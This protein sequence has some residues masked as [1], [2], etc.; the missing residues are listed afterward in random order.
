[1]IYPYMHNIGLDLYIYTWNNTIQKGYKEIWL[2]L[3][4]QPH[5]TCGIL[6]LN[7][8]CQGFHICLWGCEHNLHFFLDLVDTR[9][10]PQ[11]RH[12]WIS[13]FKC[14][15]IVLLL[16]WIPTYENLKNLLLIWPFNKDKITI[17]LCEVFVNSKWHIKCAISKDWHQFRSSYKNL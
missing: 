12:E 10:G 16:I 1:M 13:S 4:G 3:I 17:N 15:I 7:V 8:D 9:R 2:A 5:Q 11:I 6:I 14:Q